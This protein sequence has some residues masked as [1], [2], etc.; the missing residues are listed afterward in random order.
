MGRRKLI[1]VEPFETGWYVSSRYQ[2]INKEGKKV[3]TEWFIVSPVECVDNEKSC[4]ELCDYNKELV[5]NMDKS[6]KIIHEYKPMYINEE[7]DPTIEIRSI[8]KSYKEKD[9]KKSKKQA[10]GNHR[11]PV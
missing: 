10:N 7:N 4:I 11:Q 1:N 8:L 5:K 6:L 9:I 3:F 2:Y